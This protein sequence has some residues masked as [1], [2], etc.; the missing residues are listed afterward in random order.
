MR[1]AEV[2]ISHPSSTN[3]IDN[4]GA[5]RLRLE[6]QRALTGEEILNRVQGCLTGLERQRLMMPYQRT[7]NSPE[8]ILIKNRSF[9]ECPGE[10]ASHLYVRFKH[11]DRWIAARIANLFAEEC[12]DYFRVNEIEEWRRYWVEENQP[13]HIR[14]QEKKVDELSDELRGLSSKYPEKDGQDVSLS[15]NARRGSLQRELEV[16]K[17]ILEQLQ[18][19]ADEMKTTEP[20]KRV[21]VA[22]RAEP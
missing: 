3:E 11:P 15:E 14:Q 13:L 22:K 5:T 9:V 4:S 7:W 6:V 10:E 19:K 16:H 20:A 21:W 1:E 2:Y 8:K 17:M 18:L 12:V